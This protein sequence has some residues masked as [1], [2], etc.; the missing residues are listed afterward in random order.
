MP[1]ITVK[2]EI[3]YAWFSEMQAWHAYLIKKAGHPDFDEF[4]ILCAIK[5]FKEVKR[6]GKI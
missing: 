5:G 3:G 1:V 2:G 4:F 6:D